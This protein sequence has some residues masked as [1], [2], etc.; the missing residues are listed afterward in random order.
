MP[1]RAVLL[2]AGGLKIQPTT[3]QQNFGKLPW[4][5]PSKITVVVGRKVSHRNLENPF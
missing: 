3:S 2:T 4:H 5:Y 1:L